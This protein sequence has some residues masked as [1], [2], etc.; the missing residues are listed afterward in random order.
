MVAKTVIYIGEKKL[1]YDVT[2]ITDLFKVFRSSI[3]MEPFLFKF[4]LKP[5]SYGK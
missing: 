5:V 2:K 3:F 1:L 4:V